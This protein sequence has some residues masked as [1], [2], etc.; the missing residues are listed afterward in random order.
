[1]ES[2]E[3]ILAKLAIRDDAFIQSI[4]AGTDE[5]VVSLSG[6]EPKPHAL[7][8]IAALVALDAPMPSYMWAVELAREAG[9]TD[10][11]IVGSLVAVLPAV[12]AT[13]VVAAA[14]KLGLALGYDV[15]QALEDSGV[16]LG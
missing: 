7:A 12:G 4:L 8:R 16:L 3:G 14:P 9:V 6:L 1:M 15:G 5:A 11:E 13:R 10:R 2:T